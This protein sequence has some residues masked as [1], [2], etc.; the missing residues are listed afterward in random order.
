M[1][2]ISLQRSSF[3]LAKAGPG[4]N[5]VGGLG[6]SGYSGGGGG[7]SDNYGGDGGSNGRCFQ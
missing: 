2:R 3:F 1:S 4:G 6:G 5:A 7:D